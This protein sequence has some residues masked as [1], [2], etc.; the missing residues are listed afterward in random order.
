MISVT[1]VVMLVYDWRLALIAVFAA[2]PLVLLLRVVQR[3]LVHAYSEVRERN[4]EL[5]TSV[6]EL[7]TGAAVIRAYR[8]GPRTTKETKRTVTRHRDASIRAGTIAAPVPVGRALLGPDHRRGP[9]RRH[10]A[11]S[12]VRPD[13]R[14]DGRLHLPLLPV[15]GAGR[16]VHGDPRPDPDRRRGLASGPR[17][18]RAADH[19]HGT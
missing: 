3:H 5:L 9:R 8:L 4:A 14:R 15:P 1:A 7:V 16:R 6:S 10:R 12:R 2:A 17:D 18:P 13:H 11:R 19:H